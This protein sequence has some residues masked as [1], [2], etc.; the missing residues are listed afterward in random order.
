MSNN[1]I[2]FDPQA[3]AISGFLSNNVPRYKLVCIS[4]AASELGFSSDK[5]IDIGMTKK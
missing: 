3:N 5:N 1:R 2:H 4:T